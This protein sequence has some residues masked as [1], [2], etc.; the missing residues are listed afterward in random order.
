MVPDEEQGA[1]HARHAGAPAWSGARDARAGEPVWRDEPPV[2]GYEPRADADAAGNDDAPWPASRAHAPRPVPAT[3]HAPAGAR[4]LPG[5]AEGP[6]EVLQ[7]DEADHR[8]I[9]G[10][11]HDGRCLWAGDA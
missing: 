7:G 4:D 1:R 10:C 2:R 9:H 5:K 3:G 6:G 8:A 11:G